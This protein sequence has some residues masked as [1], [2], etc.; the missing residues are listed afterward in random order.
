MDYGRQ[1][2]IAVYCSCQKRRLR[3]VERGIIIQL[4]I[5]PHI[6]IMCTYLKNVDKDTK[7]CSSPHFLGNIIA[8][9][10]EK[11]KNNE[12]LWIKNQAFYVHKTYK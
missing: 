2:H 8:T 7:L 6:S 9:N 5:P 10:P 1:L 3:L 4:I 12:S 11:T